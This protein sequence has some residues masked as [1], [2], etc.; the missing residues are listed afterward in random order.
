[1]N[2]KEQAK[3]TE[4]S[5][6]RI[7]SIGGRDTALET[8]GVFRGFASMGIDEAGVLIELNEK[9]GDMK[10]KLRIVPL[11]SILAIDV[12]DAKPDEDA[13]DGKETHQ[14]YT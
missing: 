1:M 7:I 6:Y 14:F 11:H 2:Q 3:L 10:G 4:G 5:T 12:L 13:D 8:E 9:H